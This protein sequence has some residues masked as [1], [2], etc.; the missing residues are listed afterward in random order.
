M[1]LSTVLVTDLFSESHAGFIDEGVR[2]VIAMTT[3]AWWSVVGE[4]V[5]DPVMAEAHGCAV[6]A[7]GG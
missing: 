4:A 6:S 1:Q 2:K 3:T 7:A 5:V